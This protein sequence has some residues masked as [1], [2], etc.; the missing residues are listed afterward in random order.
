M[1]K[2]SKVTITQ[3]IT[4]VLVSLLVSLGVG[5]IALRHIHIKEGKTLNEFREMRES[6]NYLDYASDFALIDRKIDRNAY[7]EKLKVSGKKKILFFGDSFTSAGIS[8]NE[9]GDIY[10]DILLKMIKKKSMGYEG[11]NLSYGG[12]NF[13]DNN[14]VIKDSLKDLKPSLIVYQ[15][16]RNDFS[17]G[18]W[19][20]SSLS[21]C[22]S[23]TF[24]KVLK[25]NKVF[26]L[27]F[28]FFFRDVTV[29]ETLNFINDEPSLSCFSDALLKNLDLLEKSGVPIILLYHFDSV[30]KENICNEDIK[31]DVTEQ[32]VRKKKFEE[33]VSTLPVKYKINMTDLW[34]CKDTKDLLSKDEYHMNY[35]GNTIL[36][37]E[38][39]DLIQGE[40][41]LDGIKKL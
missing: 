40:Q 26:H 22:Y 5:E 20:I 7:L 41:L 1:G 39:F 9:I 25:K 6:F 16:S 2:A 38:I 24:F 23:D 30:W 35:L 28:H 37:H 19:N 17:H 14:I 32:R 10:P 11:I 13:F 15:I 33:F 34:K 36:A 21:E 3:K 4:L 29:Y 12:F 27:F 18:D 31:V 8:D